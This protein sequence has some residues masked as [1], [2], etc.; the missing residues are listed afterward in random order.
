MQNHQDLVRTFH[1]IFN[2]RDWGRIDAII[3]P[4]HRYLDVPFGR[5]LGGPAGI[6]EFFG[7]WA[8]AFPDSRAE[9]NEL[10]SGEQHV[11]DLFTF[12]GTHTAPL[13]GPGG[14]IPATGRAV[15]VAGCFYFEARGG[16]LIASRNYYDLTTILRQLGVVA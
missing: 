1:D 15:E 2:R 5:T 6:R 9:I 8:D 11:V 4:E 16:K 10:H 3:A 13:V 7:V 12:R 14:T